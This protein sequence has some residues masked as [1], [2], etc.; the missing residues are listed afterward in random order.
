[1]SSDVEILAEANDLRQRISN[2]EDIPPETV[3]KVL[4]AM[5]EKRGTIA[6][7]SNKIAAA[8]AALPMDLNDLFSK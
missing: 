6:S 4:R 5:A 8:S 2:G 1:M 7:A 3:A